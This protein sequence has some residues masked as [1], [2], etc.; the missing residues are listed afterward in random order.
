MKAWQNSAISFGAAIALSWRE[1]RIIEGRF[2]KARLAEKV[3]TMKSFL[4]SIATAGAVALLLSFGALAQ[5]HKWAGRTLDDLEQTIHERLEVLPMH[6]VFDTLNF[7]VQG[8]TVTL[9]GFVVKESIAEKAV[10][11]VKQLD[12]VEN[13]V[14]HVEVLPSSHRDDVLRKNLYRAIFE[15]TDPG[16]GAYAGT[17]IHIIVKNGYVTLE[18]V[19]NSEVDRSAI[20]LKAVHTT[21]HVTDNLRVRPEQS[22]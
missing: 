8:K 7:E 15:N 22:R 17:A 14:N 11:A 19:V 21:A 5:E 18:G 4:S 10:R 9:S 16:M 1:G 3:K 12:G 13:V 2:L 20:Y 6:G